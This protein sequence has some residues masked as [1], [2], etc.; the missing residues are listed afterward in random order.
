MKIN[1]TFGRIENTPP[2]C[3]YEQVANVNLNGKTSGWLY[4]G[5]K[6]SEKKQYTLVTALHKVHFEADTYLG[7]KKE[8]SEHC[9][10]CF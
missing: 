3:E 4:S 6:G 9:T 7:A 2:H 5:K 10:F 1:I 8:V